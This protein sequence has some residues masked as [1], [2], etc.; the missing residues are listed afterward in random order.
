MKMGTV[1]WFSNSKGFG[2]IQP[3]GGGPDIFIHFS[4]IQMDGF[5][6]LESGAE[7]SFEVVQG[8]KGQQAH[9]LIVTSRPPKDRVC[10]NDGPKSKEGRLRT[11]QFRANLMGSQDRAPQF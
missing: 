5:K 1:K 4:A 3:M 2:F 6:T 9:E 8:P 7:V 10:A 11:P